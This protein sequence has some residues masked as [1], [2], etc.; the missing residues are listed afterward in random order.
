MRRVSLRPVRS[1]VAALI[2]SGALTAASSASA[3]APDFTW[4]GP[5]AADAR[6]SVAANWVGGAAPAPNSTVGTLSFGAESPP[7]CDSFNCVTVHNDVSG[8][9]VGALWITDPR[10]KI[11]GKALT[12]GAGGLHARYI[13]ASSQGVVAMPITLGADQTWTVDRPA[14]YLDYGSF[15]FLQVQGAV[16]GT[17]ALTV[18][19]DAHSYIAFLN[20]AD[21]GPD[22]GSEVGSVTFNAPPSQLG[23]GHDRL[24]VRQ[25]LVY[26]SLN[27]VSGNPITVNHTMLEAAA[28]LGSVHLRDGGLHLMYPGG[29][30]TISAAGLTMDA[31]SHFS[32]NIISDGTDRGVD[33]SSLSATGAVQLAGQVR[34][35]SPWGHCFEP[36]V[37][38]SYTLIST[39]GPLSGAFE[40][41]VSA[42][43]ESIYPGYGCADMSDRLLEY[44]YDRTSMPRTVK[45]VAVRSTDPAPT[46]EPTPLATPTPGPAATPTP[47]PAATPAPTP[48]P[49]LVRPNG[50]FFEAATLRMTNVPL[51]PTKKGVCPKRVTITVTKAKLKATKRVPVE[52]SGAVCLIRSTF[53]LKG[54]L[55]KASTVKVKVSGKGVRT[56]TKTVKAAKK[57][58]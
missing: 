9:S 47:T 36:K 6:W 7:S 13:T 24:L 46:P 29:A 43:R 17:Q 53:K 33:Y 51:K 23:Y 22:S 11:E 20:S 19:L 25:A 32:I 54:K 39:T 18:E 55:A 15:G 14:D 27:A 2:A 52:R 5:A 21:T 37:G 40:G 57:A 12:L 3:G 28:D 44:R 34:L 48:T 30:D 1:L 56:T 41:D 45:M 10:I 38:D 8:L 35:T 16:T 49:T 50:L 58:R 31:D 26:S 4:Q 42:D